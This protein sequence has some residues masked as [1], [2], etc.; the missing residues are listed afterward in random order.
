[1]NSRA[2]R[3]ARNNLMDKTGRTKQASERFAGD[4]WNADEGHS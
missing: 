4:T 1:M 3:M 2:K